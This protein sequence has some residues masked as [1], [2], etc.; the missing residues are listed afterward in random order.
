M[1][2]YGWGVEPVTGEHVDRRRDGD[3]TASM[4]RSPTC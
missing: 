1:P 3:R 2:S 4:S